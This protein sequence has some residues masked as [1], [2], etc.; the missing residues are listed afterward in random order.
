V[1]AAQRD[2]VRVRIYSH[3]FG[4]QGSAADQP[5]DDEPCDICGGWFID[6]HLHQV[7]ATPRCR[8]CGK[9]IGDKKA[10]TLYCSRSCREKSHREEAKENSHRKFA[11]DARR[12]WDGLAARHAAEGHYAGDGCKCPCATCRTSKQPIESVR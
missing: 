3:R 2:L 12:S 6:H 11:R 1:T 8:Y 9:S 5:R 4:A 7:D 10:G